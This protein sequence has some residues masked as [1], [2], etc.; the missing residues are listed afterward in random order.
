MKDLRNELFEYLKEIETLKEKNKNQEKEIN[1]LRSDMEAISKRVK[2]V[3]TDEEV[4]EL[5]YKSTK[6]KPMNATMMLEVIKS[7]IPLRT[8][9]LIRNVQLN[10]TS[11]IGVRFIKPN[12][13]QKRGKFVLKEAFI[14]KSDR[15]PEHGSGQLY[16]INRI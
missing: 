9:M 12:L 4:L 13:N 3:M 1:R 10:S 16:R 11:S 14:Y 2:D 8:E 7:S 5:I 15:L 6:E